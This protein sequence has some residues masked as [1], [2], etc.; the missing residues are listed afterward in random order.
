MPVF[1]ILGSGRPLVAVSVAANGNKR[2][3][4][5]VVGFFFFFFLFFLFLIKFVPATALLV[6]APTEL[7][8]IFFHRW[9]CADFLRSAGLRWLVQYSIF[10]LCV[11][12]IVF[13]WSRNSIRFIDGSWWWPA[14]SFTG[15]WISHYPLKWPFI[16]TCNTTI[17][18]LLVFYSC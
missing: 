16:S 9:N 15:D 1:L 17:L 4:T 11:W 3:S 18:Y 14:N 10:L 12:L 7:N 5:S 13:V 2:T 8:L 6:C